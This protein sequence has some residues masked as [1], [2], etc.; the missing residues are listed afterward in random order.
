M[1]F[2]ILMKSILEDNISFMAQ[3][4]R[5]ITPVKRHNSIADAL[6]LCLLHEAII[7]LYSQWASIITHTNLASYI[8]RSLLSFFYVMDK[9]KSSWQFSLLWVNNWIISTATF[10]CS[11]HILICHKIPLATLPLYCINLHV[12]KQIATHCKMPGPP[13]NINTCLSR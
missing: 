9:K 7:Y 5:D 10:C 3:C 2:I 4:K 1:N 11:C 8:A 12:W 6:E 13:F